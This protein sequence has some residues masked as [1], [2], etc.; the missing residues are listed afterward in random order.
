M[1]GVPWFGGVNSGYRDL[2]MIEKV[3]EMR[4]DG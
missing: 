2:I 4:V 1:D 3:L